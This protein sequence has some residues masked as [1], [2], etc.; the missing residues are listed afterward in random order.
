[1]FIRFIRGHLLI[2]T[3][4]AEAI[5]AGIKHLIAPCG[6]ATGEPGTVT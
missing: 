6:H 5:K 4:Q 3:R 2:P 1:L